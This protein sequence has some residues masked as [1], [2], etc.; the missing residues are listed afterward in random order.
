MLKMTIQTL[1][2]DLTDK[3]EHLRYL[4]QKCMFNAGVA[5]MAIKHFDCI[6]HCRYSRMLDM[7]EYHE[8][9]EQ[10]QKSVELL[11]KKCVKLKE[12]IDALKVVE[13]KLNG[14]EWAL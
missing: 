13:S 9:S 8:E 14:G 12:Q 11:R 4:I 3:R 5:E 10:M 7:S 1:I 2:N 6:Y